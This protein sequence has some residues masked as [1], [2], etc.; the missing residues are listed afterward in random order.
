MQGMQAA[1]A[2]TATSPPP[3]AGKQDD[4]SRQQRYGVTVTALCPGM[5]DTGFADRLCPLLQQYKWQPL[6]SQ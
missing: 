1:T 6:I 4:H 2:S 3:T 5:S